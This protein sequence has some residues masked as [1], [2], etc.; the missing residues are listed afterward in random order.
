MTT[1]TAFQIGTLVDINCAS[2]GSLYR[3]ILTGH[4]ESVNGDGTS[5]VRGLRTEELY[6]NVP[7]T[8]MSARS[9]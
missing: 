2:S 5:N 8:A 9:E 4:V 7:A 1:A 3:E 6:R